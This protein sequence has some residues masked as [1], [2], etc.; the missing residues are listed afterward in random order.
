[1]PSVEKTLIGVDLPNVQAPIGVRSMT[2]T[3]VASRPPLT[4]NGGVEATVVNVMERGLVGALVVWQVGAGEGFLKRLHSFD[5]SIYVYV[6][7]FIY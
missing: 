7:I 2:F 3:P 6:Y 5:V 1:M 4:V